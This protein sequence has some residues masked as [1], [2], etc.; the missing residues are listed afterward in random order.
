[1][2]AIAA[3]VYQ[4]LS[5]C[6]VKWTATQER[7][8]GSEF[9]FADLHLE[10]PDDYVS[11]IYLQHL[12]LPES[13]MPLSCLVPSLLRVTV[14][15]QSSSQSTR[16]P[17]PLQTLLLPL[18]LTPRTCSQ[19]YQTHIARVLADDGGAG[20]V[21]ESVMWYALKFEKTEDSH[22]RDATQ[23]QEGS[24]EENWRHSWLARME[25][26]EV[27]I[28]ILLHFLLLSLPGVP[29]IDDTRSSSSS[30]RK[31]KRHQRDDPPPS[32][33]VLEEHLEFLMDKL[34]MWQLMASLDGTAGGTPGKPTASRPDVKGK[35]KAEDERDWMQIFCE[36]V[37]ER[38]FRNK[39]PEQCSLLRSKVFQDSPFSDF[40]DGP[41][42]SP[43]PS[44]PQKHKRLKQPAALQDGEKKGDTRSRSRSLSMS[45]EQERERSRSASVDPGN[46]RKRVLAREV[47]MSKGFKGKEKTKSK[48]HLPVTKL[49]SSAGPSDR[50]KARSS[51]TRKNSSKGT[52]LV[53]ATP[54][55][56]GGRISKDP[57]IPI[58]TDAPSST[59]AAS[60]ITPM[61]ADGRRS[62]SPVVEGD[63][64]DAEWTLP[65]SPDI[66]LLGSQGKDWDQEV[67]D[68]RH[69]LSRKGG[70]IPATGTPTKPRRK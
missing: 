61:T 44:P 41:D 53:T 46:M 30:P 26:R 39:L 9:P 54:T 32:I 43:P 42:Q 31:R 55:K 23:D 7:S 28:Q 48:S 67:E 10:T 12:W 4:L 14:E 38:L 29:T 19:K 2:A 59:P 17:H 15:P 25:R 60:G 56:P 8:I 16:S 3:P 62:R 13:I 24:I 33:S 1:M 66:L 34:S 36:D 40:S 49:K 58:R 63:D 69:L 11:R 47:S 57:P 52:I 6:S 65:S 68:A 22:Q 5:E 20:D 27:Q 50:D 45:L 51:S 64:Q 21:E 18:L 35:Q 37:V 70:C